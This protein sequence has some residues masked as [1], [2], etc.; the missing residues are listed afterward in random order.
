MPIPGKYQDPI[1]KFSEEPWRELL[2]TLRVTLNSLASFDIVGSSPSRTFHS[3]QDDRA[4]NHG[5]S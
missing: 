3:A 2:R 5:R 4:F 1:E